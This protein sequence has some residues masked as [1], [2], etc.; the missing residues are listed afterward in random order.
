VATGRRCDQFG[1]YAF[2]WIAV[3]QAQ[4]ATYGAG[5]SLAQAR[6]VIAAAVLEGEKQHLPV[7][8]AVVDPAGLLVSFER[9]DD[10]QT[11]S[12]AIAEDKAASAAKFRRPTKVFQDSLAAGGVGLR[13]LSLR[14]AVAADGGM[15][16][17]VGGK[18]VGAVGVSGG[19]AEQD[20]SLAR[21]ASSALP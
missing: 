10:T 14:G 4:P 1:A 11:A 3:A 13:V 7:A 2:C 18:V 12:I 17:L 8:V 19:T 15:P 21:A 5:I 16:L 9:M 6:R 20:G